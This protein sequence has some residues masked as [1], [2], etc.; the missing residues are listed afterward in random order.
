[1]I[2]DKRYE[3]YKRLI[4]KHRTDKGFLDEGCDS[5]LFSSLVAMDK[6]LDFDIDAAYDLS[7]IHI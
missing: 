2:N 4:G 5:I 7:L 6:D 3:I 1:M